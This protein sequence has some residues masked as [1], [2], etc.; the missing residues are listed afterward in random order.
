MRV[1]WNVYYLAVVVTVVAG[2]RQW[3]IPVMEKKD[4]V[5]EF[6]FSRGCER[7][8][9][10]RKLRLQSSSVRSCEK[11]MAK[12]GASYASYWSAGKRNEG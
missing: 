7:R 8:C 6:T 4:Q 5:S 9:G 3:E 11:A 1:T 12:K 2:A 10:D